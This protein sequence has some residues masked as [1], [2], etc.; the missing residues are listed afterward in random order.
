MKHLALP[1]HALS[2]VRHT[3]CFAFAAP[4]AAGLHRDSGSRLRA[5]HGGEA[6]EGKIPYTPIV[7][8]IPG[9]SSSTPFAVK[10]ACAAAL[11]SLIGG[12]VS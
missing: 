2:A 3:L 5:V 10:A 8:P 1:N 9:K 4:L 6:A 7:S 12:K 11:S